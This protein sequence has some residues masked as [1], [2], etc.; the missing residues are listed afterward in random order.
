MLS[1]SL[2]TY[3]YNLNFFFTLGKNGN[4][5]AQILNDDGISTQEITTVQG[6]IVN[7][8]HNFKLTQATNAE[9]IA[10]RLSM[11]KQSGDQI[12]S[13]FC[14]YLTTLA[15]TELIDQQIN[16]KNY[17]R[18]NND[19]IERLQ[20]ENEKYE[21]AGNIAECIQSQKNSEGG[22]VASETLQYAL[23]KIFYDRTVGRS[24]F[25]SAGGGTIVP[26]DNQTENQIVFASTPRQSNTVNIMFQNTNV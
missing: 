10:S 14:E 16:I 4:D 12:F 19:Q 23:S 21:E 8:I 1:F 22:L 24:R 20:K 2:T 18:H 5:I 9:E 3:L 17:N 7:F 25:A 13:A 15:D 6:E 11:T 26:M